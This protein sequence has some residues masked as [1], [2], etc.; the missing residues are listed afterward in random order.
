MKFV[1]LGFAACAAFLPPIPRTTWRKVGGMWFW[2]IGPIG[3]TF[4]LTRKG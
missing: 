4:Y 3:G 2:R 1:M